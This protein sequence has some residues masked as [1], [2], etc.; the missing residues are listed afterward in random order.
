MIAEGGKVE[1]NMPVVMTSSWK[2]LLVPVRC[3]TVPMS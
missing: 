1:V 2:A 3:I